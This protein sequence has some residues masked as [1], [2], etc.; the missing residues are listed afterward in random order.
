MFSEQRWLLLVSQ[1][2]RMSGTGG[3]LYSALSNNRPSEAQMLKA[4]ALFFCEY[5]PFIQVPHVFA[6]HSIMEAFKGASR[7]HVIDYGILYGLQWPCLLWQLSQRPGGP[8]HLRITG[9]TY[10]ISLCLNLQ[11]MKWV[12]VPS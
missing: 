7:V 11:G 1:V 2:A 5:C 4:Q 8:P 12:I 3:R 9:M 10:F 6:N